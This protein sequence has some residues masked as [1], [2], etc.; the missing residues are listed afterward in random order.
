[1]ADLALFKRHFGLVETRYYYFTTLALA[2]FVHLKLFST[3]LK[4]TEALDQTL[5]RLP[6]LQKQAWQILIQLSQPRH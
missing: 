1:M 3:L 5:F 2:P 4:A 6:F